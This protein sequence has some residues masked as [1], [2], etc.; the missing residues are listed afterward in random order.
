MH[1]EPMFENEVYRKKNC[2]ESVIYR[3]STYQAY[4]QNG[5]CDA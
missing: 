4:S 1:Y 3:I 2:D 5:L